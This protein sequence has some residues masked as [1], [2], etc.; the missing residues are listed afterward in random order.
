[1]MYS[2]NNYWNAGW[3]KHLCLVLQITRGCSTCRASRRW[4]PADVLATDLYQDARTAA[5]ANAM[6]ATVYSR[7][8]TVGRY[9]HSP[10]AHHALTAATPAVNPATR[11]LGSPA[12]RLLAHLSATCPWPSLVPVGIAVRNNLAIGFDSTLR[13]TVLDGLISIC[14]NFHAFRF[15][16]NVFFLSDMDIF[17]LL[18]ADIQEVRLFGLC[19][20]L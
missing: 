14:I 20:C 13:F 16:M 10:V 5:A 8:R 4:W 15:S 17:N 12:P 7:A 2:V 9:A 11:S 18:F 6:R 3:D 1:M 19:F